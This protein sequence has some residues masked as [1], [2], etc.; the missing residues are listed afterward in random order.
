MLLYTA[1]IGILVS[2]AATICVYVIR[3]KQ[4]EKER[5]QYY[6]GYEDDIVG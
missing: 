1:I 5:E 6:T 3:I 4:F 2:G